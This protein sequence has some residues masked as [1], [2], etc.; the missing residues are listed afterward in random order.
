MVLLRK[1]EF[2]ELSQV[3]RQLIREELSAVPQREKKV[4][5]A[6]NK[7]QTTEQIDLAKIREIGHEKAS[8]EIMTS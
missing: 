5:N 7:I 6:I 8:K 2:D 1:E 4:S 3:I